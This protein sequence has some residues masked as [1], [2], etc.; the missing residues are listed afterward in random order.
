MQN[1]NRLSH[2][3]G[4]KPGSYD[5]VVRA[6]KYSVNPGDR[7][8]L[9]VYISGYG[10]IENA[11]VGIFPS[12]SI[13]DILESRVSVGEGSAEPWDPLGVIISINNESFF[14]A[15]GLFQISTEVRTPPPKSKAPINLDLKVNKASLPGVQFIQFTFKYFNGES[16]NTETLTIS[17]V[18]RNF[19]Q[20]NET[21]VWL[22]GGIAAFISII[23]SVYPI[24]Q[25]IFNNLF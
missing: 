19:Y 4:E 23:T 14:D 2:S 16:W 5:I 3:H 18:V 17:I 10:R 9:E 15:K 7:V 1:V 20:R 24:V 21:L 13:F 12:S 11:S 6:S 22:I 8:E 25:W